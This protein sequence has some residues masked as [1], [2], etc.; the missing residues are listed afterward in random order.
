MAWAHPN[1]G[2]SSSTSRS[3]TLAHLKSPSTLWGG[4]TGSGH[5]DLDIL[6]SGI[7]PTMVFSNVFHDEETCYFIVDKT[8]IIYFI[9]PSR[10]THW[11]CGAHLLYLNSKLLGKA[12]V[13]LSHLMPW[14]LMLPL[15]RLS[16]PSQAT[17][18]RKALMPGTCPA[19]LNLPALLSPLLWDM[20]WGMSVMSAA[21]PGEAL[22]PGGCCGLRVLHPPSSSGRSDS[23]RAMA[24]LPFPQ[25]PHCPGKSCSDHP[26]ARPEP[27]PYSLPSS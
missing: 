20:G 22:P 7:Q 5:Q 23:P 10:Q 24:G 9:L 19:P 25:P 6:G 27:S 13:I 16:S 3:P 4:V 14:M 2:E 12:H 17:D 1:Y 26:P 18:S 15:Q 11:K 21:K 8:Y